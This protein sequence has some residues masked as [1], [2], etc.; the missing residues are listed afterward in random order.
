MKQF[1]ENII[2]NVMSKPSELLK[3]IIDTLIMVGISGAISFVLGLI[4][5]IIITVT[6]RGGVLENT[7][8]YNILDKAIN[9]FRAIPFI[10]LL[11]WVLPISRAI[12]GSGIGVQGAIVPLVFG[13]VPFFA[14]QIE[15]ALAEVS[16]GVIEAAQAMGL[17]PFAIIFKVYL[18]EGIPTIARATTL[19]AINLIGLTAMAGVVGA[20]GLGDFAIRY[21][22]NRFQEDVTWVTVIIIVVIV[23]IVQLVGDLTVKKNTH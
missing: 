10:I 5:G 7:I 8:V 9:I 6:K 17:S 11:T 13:V 19:T 21:G 15:S 18:R 23:T 12:V 2:P 14:R 3:A 4:F 1:L 20:G 16:P 22:H